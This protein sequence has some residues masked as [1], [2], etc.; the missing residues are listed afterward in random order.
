MSKNITIINPEKNVCCLPGFESFDTA[1]IA[2]RMPKRKYLKSIK[3][4]RFE[5]E[6]R[7]KVYKHAG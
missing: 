3:E 6:A 2:K 1:S 7:G 4:L 5:K